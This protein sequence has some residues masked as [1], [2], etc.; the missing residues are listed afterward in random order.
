MT[1]HAPGDAR[2]H[3]PS[4]GRRSPAPPWRSPRP[5]R[6]SRTAAG[7]DADADRAVRGRR[8]RSARG[9]GSARPPR[10]SW[11]DALRAM[12]LPALTRAERVRAF[13]ERN[14][15]TAGRAVAGQPDPRRPARAGAAISI[16]GTVRL[17]GEE[18]VI[19]ARRI[20]LDTGRLVEQTTDRAPLPELF[21]LHDRVARRLMGRQ[22]TAGGTPAAT[23]AAPGRSPLGAFENYIKGLIAEQPAAQ[24]RFLQAALRHRAAGTP[25]PTWR[26]GGLRRSGRS[27]RARWPRPRPCRRRRRSAAGR[28]SWPAARWS[29]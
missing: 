10:C 3:A 11:R 21:A 8:S 14:L 12:Q 24:I 15:P 27:R 20:R 25:G 13:E 1:A 23:P 7:H 17:S 4:A 6:R 26:W 29:S 22:P 9:A 16:V 2:A 28:G 19:D 5:P 18:L